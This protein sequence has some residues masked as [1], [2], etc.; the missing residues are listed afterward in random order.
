MKLLASI[1][2]SYFLISAH[3]EN[4]KIDSFAL[5]KIKIQKK[6]DFILKFNKNA[7][8]S[9]L[10]S[11]R[12]RNAR[13]AF[14]YKSLVNHTKLSQKNVVDF[15]IRHQVE[16]QQFYINNTIVA[17]N[18]DQNLLSQLAEF[19][20]I[21]AISFD[22]Q[23]RTQLPAL[24]FQFRLYGNSPIGLS[25][26][27]DNIKA[28]KADQVWSNLK[29]TGKGIVIA[30][31]DTGFNWTHPALKKKYRGFTAF[32]T[33]H[34]YNWHDTAKKNACIVPCD[35][36][37]HGTHTM[38]IMLGDDGQ[39]NQIGVAPDAKWIGCRN[40]DNGVG[41]VSSY[42]ECFQF[43]LAPYPLGGNAL[44]DGRSEFAPHIINNSWGCPADEGC[45]G[46]EFIQAVRNLKAAGIFVVV[47][48][49]NDGPSC[50][51]S[52]HA[53][54]FYSGELTTVAAYDHRNGEVTDFSSRGPST[55]N[56][57]LGP[58]ITA[59]GES[60]RSSVVTKEN[61]SARY[62]S[63]SGTSMAG[64]H[65]AGVV[66][67]MWSAHPELIGQVDATTRIIEKT[68]Q[69][70]TSTQSCAPYAGDHI[71]NAVYGYGLVD[72]FAAVNYKP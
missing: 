62:E 33:L 41:T 5:A 68:A 15:L 32:N 40:M 31:N 29:I 25:G 52:G 48:G 57:G 24:Q 9:D 22:A 64:P 30:G 54:G 20:E 14:L 16:F 67:L 72:A 27:E 45:Q 11:I 53:P 38:G 37:D 71:P 51:S 66:A 7:D 47:S 36:R 56:N 39:G 19:D 17:Y 12:S 63:L 70:K 55:W 50:G 65:I 69:P 21:S 46:D 43:L 8:I 35:D 26:I 44:T 61:Q 1:C 6:A 59:P 34:D 23:I 58:N 49:G 60:I 28:I 18:I 2:I 4:F 3:A 13:L 10:S 42:T